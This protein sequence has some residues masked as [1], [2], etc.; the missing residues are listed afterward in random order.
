MDAQEV[1][2]EYYP[3]LSPEAADRVV[4]ILSTKFHAD[5]DRMRQALTE[6]DETIRDSI[7][8]YS[9]Y[10]HSSEFE[11]VVTIVTNIILMMATIEQIHKECDEA[12]NQ[13][14]V[15][16]LILNHLA[17][18]LYQSEINNGEFTNCAQMLKAIAESL[19][20]LPR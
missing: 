20:N 17:D 10:K 18:G 6:V 3:H 15:C 7:G 19:P 1:I 11:M 16:R 14:E 2:L 12:P 5:I 13:R 4:N 8:N 9:K